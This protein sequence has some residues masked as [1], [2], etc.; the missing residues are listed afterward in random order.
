RCRLPLPKR[1][2]LAGT[3]RWGKGLLLHIHPTALAALG[4]RIDL[5]ERHDRL[6]DV[7]TSVEAD[8]AHHG[9]V[10]LA[11]REDVVADSGAPRGHVTTGTCGR[12]FHGLDDD[13]SARE[14]ESAVCHRSLAE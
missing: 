8:G 11:T 4:R 1:Q 13:L 7:T 5:V 9:A 6:L 2:E 3:R 14:G 10:R 12:F